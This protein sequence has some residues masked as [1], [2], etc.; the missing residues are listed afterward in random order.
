MLGAGSAGIGVGEQIVRS[1]VADG[2]SDA[3]ARARVY[4][5]D[6]RGLLTADR[7]D[8]NPAQRRLAQPAAGSPAAGGRPVRLDGRRGAADRADRVVD[9]DRCVHRGHRPAD[10]RARERPII[11]PLSNPTSRSEARPQDLA[12]WTGGRRWW[13]PVP[14]FPPMQ[15]GRDAIPVAQCNNVYIF[16][17][18]GLAVTAVRATRVT[19]ACG[20]GV[21]GRPAFARGQ[22]PG[23]QRQHPGSERHR[24]H[25]P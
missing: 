9:R 4:V 2:L 5:V 25:R 6:V 8:L 18:I 24:R 14:P 3:D 22:A 16:P 19:V 17:G 13:R 7:T 15:V 12:D 11:L 20:V 10:G 1:M 21:D 23:P